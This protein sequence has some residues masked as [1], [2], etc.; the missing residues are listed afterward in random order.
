MQSKNRTDGAQQTAPEKR[1]LSPAA[2]RALAEAEERRQAADASAKE[3][4]KEIGGR[5]GPDP[6][7]YGDWEKGGIASDF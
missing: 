4:A 7:R 5:D 3:R 6:A 2:K 1:E